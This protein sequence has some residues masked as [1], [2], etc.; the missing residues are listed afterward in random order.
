[1]PI[2][3]VIRAQARAWCRRLDSTDAL[4]VIT[5]QQRALPAFA[6]LAP[7]QFEKIAAAHPTRS[8]WYRMMG[9]G[10]FEANTI[11]TAHTTIRGIFADAAA[12]LDASASRRSEERRGGQGCVSTGRNRMSPCP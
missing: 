10:G 4:R 7:D 2:N 12:M 11:E 3:A 5:F 1:M 8:S 9:Q 6:A